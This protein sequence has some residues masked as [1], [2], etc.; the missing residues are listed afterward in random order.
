MN[1]LHDRY[2][3]AGKISNDDMLYTLGLFALEPVRWTDLYDWRQLTQ[4]ERCALGV[5]W[6]DMGES[7]EISF[8]QLNLQDSADSGLAW[9]NA[10]QNWCSNYEAEN[11]VS[12]K[13]NE[14]L[15]KATLDIAMFNVPK[16]LRRVTLKLISALLEP[17]LRR[18]MM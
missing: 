13:T 6:K 4:V 18:A 9:L 15:S 2:R 3:K 16:L 11:M 5:L 10:L 1:Y 17:R 8:D 7:M 12:A 14:E